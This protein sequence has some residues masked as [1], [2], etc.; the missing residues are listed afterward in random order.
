MWLSTE[1]QVCHSPAQAYA[2]LLLLTF[3][4]L[5]LT[6]WRFMSHDTSQICVSLGDRLS[7]ASR[8]EPAAAKSTVA[9]S[10]QTIIHSGQCSCPHKPQSP[11]TTKHKGRVSYYGIRE[12]DKNQS[13]HLWCLKRLYFFSPNYFILL[14]VFISLWNWHLLV[15]RHRLIRT[16]TASRSQWSA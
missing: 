13:I 11:R 7:I 5:A 3:T 9:A 14:P 12:L 4:W 8:H 10:A 2:S 1:Q 15:Q 6:V 16:H